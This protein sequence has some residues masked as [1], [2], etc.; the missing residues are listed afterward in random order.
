MKRRIQ[1]IAL[2]VAAILKILQLFCPGFV[3]LR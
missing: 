2:T 3:V 1:L